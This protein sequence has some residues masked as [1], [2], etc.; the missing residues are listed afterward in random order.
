MGALAA[1]ATVRDE[2]AGRV[3]V[4]GC[5]ADEIHAPGTIARGSGKTLSAQAGA[6]DDID[7]AL[8]AHPE[9]VDTALRPHRVDAA[10]HRTRGRQT[11]AG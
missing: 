10:G 7:A 6:W 5:P 2:L 1:L 8:Y 9:P 3:V 4:M 11:V